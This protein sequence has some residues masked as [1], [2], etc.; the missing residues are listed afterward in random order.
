MANRKRH[1]REA[2]GD[3]GINTIGK[4]QDTLPVQEGGNQEG[5]HEGSIS[6]RL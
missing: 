3:K 5:L 4:I 2:M 6:S 1:T